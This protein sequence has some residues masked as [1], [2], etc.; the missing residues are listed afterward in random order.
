MQRQRLAK[1]LVVARPILVVCLD[2]EAQCCIPLPYPDISAIVV[3]E[4]VHTG[5]WPYDTL[6]GYLCGVGTLKNGL[7][8][9]FIGTFYDASRVC[10]SLVSLWWSLRDP[11]WAPL[12]CR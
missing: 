7:E 9:R 1:R 11:D 3:C 12:S 10:G 6:S 5:L 2:E 4:A 8:G